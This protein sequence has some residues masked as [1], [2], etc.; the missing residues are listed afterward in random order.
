MSSNICGL[1]LDSANAAGKQ[2]PA[3]RLRRLR[4]SRRKLFC[5]SLSGTA[6]SDQTALRR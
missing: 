4:F 2:I 6:E 1:F 5:Q 3:A